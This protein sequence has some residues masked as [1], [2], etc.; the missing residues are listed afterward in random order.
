MT[1]LQT[2]RYVKTSGAAIF[3]FKKSHIF[4]TVPASTWFMGAKTQQLH[5]HNKTGGK[6]NHCTRRDQKDPTS[7]LAAKGK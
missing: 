1:A 3:K 6:L 7:S 2:L 5:K 4:G